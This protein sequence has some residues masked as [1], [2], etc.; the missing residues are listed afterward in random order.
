VSPRDDCAWE[1]PGRNHHNLASDHARVEF[2]R[3]AAVL[4]SFLEGLEVIDLKTIFS[5]RKFLLASY[6][7]ILAFIA[8]AAAVAPAQSLDRISCV[9]K[10]YA[11]TGTDTCRA[12]LT[13]T[14]STHLYI[15][16]SS[17][18]P[19]VTVPSG[20]TVS[21]YAGSKGFTANIGSVTKPQTA[22]I[23]ARLNGLS[24]SFTI[25]LA[26]SS[27]ASAG[28]SINAKS[29]GFGSVALNSPQEQSLRISSTGTAPLI[30]NS[31]AVSGT[32]FSIS[33]AALPATINPG[34]SI[35]LQVLFDPLKAGTFSG[36]LSIVSN[37]STA[38]IPLSGNGASHQV[39]LNW[40]APAAAADPIVA[41][42]VYRAPS[43]ASSF[44]RVNSSPDSSP[45]FTDGTVQSG[46]AY[47]YRVTSLDS[48]GLESSP[49]NKI[50]VI[51]P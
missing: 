16:L 5:N 1:H 15:A 37:A 40:N 26:P 46:T 23:T 48:A 45:T 49:S 12:F 24:K 7:S 18:N 25:S 39:E 17:N 29:I 38:S 34:Q 51:V 8:A 44:A 30:V 50:S 22:V 19:A 3:H 33:G 43:G 21:Y 35:S 13:T 10:T 4:R 42:N 32:G 47:D 9:A 28:M 20:V 6:A 14:N 36:Q 11:S 31:A 2:A 27:T 41:Y